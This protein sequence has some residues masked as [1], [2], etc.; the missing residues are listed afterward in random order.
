MIRHLVLPAIA[1]ALSTG[2]E[3]AGQPVAPSAEIPRA[4]VADTPRDVQHPA[5]NRQ[6]LV[7]S[8]GE[9]M[10]G[11]FFLAPGEGPKPTLLLL[12]GLPGNERNLDLAQAVRRAGWNVLT[13]TYR[14]AWGSPGRFT[15]AGAIEDVAAAMALLRDPGTAAEYG[16]DSERLVI[17]GHSMGGMAGAMHAAR[18]PDI[19]GLILIDAWNAGADA[20]D[21]A[22]ATPEQRRAAAATFDDLGNSLT[23]ATGETLVE[24][25]AARGSG[26]N[27]LGVAPALARRPLL[28]VFAAE[29]IAEQNR[30]L[31]AA[32]ERHDGARIRRVELR[33]DHSFTD[34][35][36]ALAAEVVRW[37]EALP[38]QPA[39]E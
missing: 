18:D 13:F 8:H 39:G 36:I 24:E 5:R 33:T 22:R 26:W 16:V 30:D 25:L 11:L 3:A 9:G 1:W 19:A 31:A 17:A 21:L 35:R 29:G 4:V 15:I 10:N 12:H 7:P 14:G 38:P 23:G 6:L 28:T 32:V 37:L 20:A 27:L 34:H 2:P